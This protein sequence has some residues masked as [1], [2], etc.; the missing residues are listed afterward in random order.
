MISSISSIGKYITNTTKPQS[1]PDIVMDL[2]SYTSTY[3]LNFETFSTTDYPN[4]NTNYQYTTNGSVP[5]WHAVP[6]ALFHRGTRNNLISIG[7]AMMGLNTNSNNSNQN[8][9]THT[10]FPL[11]AGT[12]Y[13]QFQCAGRIA[14]VGGM[15][16]LYSTNNSNFTIIDT[17][18]EPPYPA[19]GSANLA[20]PQY[21]HTTPQF[22]LP[23]NCIFYLRF[24]NMVYTE[25]K[26]SYIVFDNIQI[27]QA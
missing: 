14:N 27:F 20:D 3:N 26:N 16:I 17:I 23:F 25:A 9:L 15:H 19:S 10:G 18:V 2:S 7:S 13:L 24:E 1:L 4:T 22:T 8:K 12:Y 11:N 21:L 6:Q 5:Q